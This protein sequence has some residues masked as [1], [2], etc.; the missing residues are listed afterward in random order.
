M[1]RSTK[2]RAV[3]S[4]RQRM[5]QQVPHDGRNEQLWVTLCRLLCDTPSKLPIILLAVTHHRVW[6]CRCPCFPKTVL[7]ALRRELRNSSHRGGRGPDILLFLVFST[8]PLLRRS[9]CAGD[10][11]ATGRVSKQFLG[12][13][14]DA[15]CARC[16]P[17]VEACSDNIPKL[18]PR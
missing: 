13:A 16:V 18:L 4:V 17:G 14:V 9:S 12:V 3:L 15:T 6:G 10:R 2:L 11:I 8:R 1:P 7:R 5:S